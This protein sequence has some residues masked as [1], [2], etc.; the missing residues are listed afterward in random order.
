MKLK[1]NKTNDD[2]TTK[3]IIKEK[4]EQFD[5]VTLINNLYLKEKIE[6]IEYTENVEEW[7]KE[8]IKSLVDK[9]NNIV[10]NPDK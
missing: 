5:Y 9:I 6:D 7:E 1:V 8:E 3:L 10:D 4:E 2:I